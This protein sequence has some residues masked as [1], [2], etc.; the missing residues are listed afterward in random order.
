LDTLVE[1]V[2]GVFFDRVEPEAAPGRSDRAVGALRRAGN[3]AK[4]WCFSE[5]RFVARLRAIVLE[6][7]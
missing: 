5:E 4:A 1:C 6:E 2:T 3:P 7:I